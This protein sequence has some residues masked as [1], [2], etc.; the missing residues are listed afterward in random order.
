MHR[1][2]LETLRELDSREMAVCR[3][4]ATLDTL[5][6]SNALVVADAYR[7]ALADWQQEIAGLVEIRHAIL[8]TLSTP[9]S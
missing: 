9:Q 4:G 8:T 3:A 6:A 1:I 7:K 2:A 5:E